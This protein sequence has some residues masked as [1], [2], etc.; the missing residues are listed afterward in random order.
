MV[1]RSVVAYSSLKRQDKDGKVRTYFPLR[2]VGL[3]VENGY[4]LCKKGGF[5]LV[6]KEGLKQVRVA[7]KLQVLEGGTWEEA[8]VV[9]LK[10]RPQD[11][12][13]A[14]KLLTAQR[15]FLSDLHFNW[16][17]T[18][19]QRS[20]SKSL[21]LVGDFSTKNNYGVTGLVW[22]ELKAF[23]K[24]GFEKKAKEARATLRTEFASLRSR[25]ASFEA[26]LFLAAE[27]EALG[28]DWGTPK[29][30]AELLTVA[31]G[32][33]QKLGGTRK[34][35]RGQAQAKPSFFRLWSR[36]EKHTTAKGGQKVRLL[37]HFLRELRLPY[38]ETTQRVKTYN[39]LLHSASR[40]ERLVQKKVLEKS[41]LPPVVGTKE[42]F[43]ELH[44]LL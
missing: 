1:L 32:E 15:A 37:K 34:A 19:T 18:D 14:V 30:K 28:R 27:C 12:A 22:V 25:D 3:A 21:D 39:K 38:N 40:A 16:F 44:K 10:L 24:V 23:G 4:K 31:K 35:A 2:A 13:L 8:S 41:G 11:E 6:A 36:L 42:V 33:W 20:G 43:R 9:S 5:G 26:V 17:C 29:L 7:G